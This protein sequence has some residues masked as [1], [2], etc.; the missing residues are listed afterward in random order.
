MS[1]TY[2]SL[3]QQMLL[4]FNNQH[5]EIAEK[6]AQSILKIN[7]EDVIALQILGLSTAMQN[8]ADEAIPPLARAAS[9]EP[10][11]PE[12]LINLVKAQQ[13]TRQFSEAIKTYE[14]LNSLMPNNFQI[15]TDM[16]TAYGKMNEYKKAYI[17]YTKAIELEPEYFL[18]WSNLGNLQLEQSLAKES[19][20]SYEVAL[21]KNSSYPETWTNYGNALYALAR[22]EEALLA[23][24]RALFLD[25]DYG[26]AWRNHGNTLMEL[27]RNE[28]A[29]VSYQKAYEIMPNQPFLIGH[30]LHGYASNCDWEGWRRLAPIA[31]NQVANNKCAVYPFIMLHSTDSHELQNIATNT[32]NKENFSSNIAH[33]FKLSADKNQ[34]IRI[35]YFSS[36]FREHPVGIL[37]E[38]ILANHDRSKFE[39]IGFFLTKPTADN[40][41]KRLVNLFDEAHDLSSMTDSMSY[42]HTRAQHLDIAIDLNGHTAG[43]K[44]ELFVKKV[45]PIQVN[46][47][48][49]AGSMN[50]S[51]YQYIIADRV[52]IPEEH[53]ALYTEK[54]AYLPHSFFPADTLIIHADLADQPS[55][56]SQ[57]L[58]E[59]GFIFACFNNS[60][61]ITQSIYEL[62]MELL[63]KTPNS[64]LWLTKP[65][66][67]A[68][69]NLQL[70]A[71]KYGVD[72]DRIIFAKRIASRKD[73]LS[74]LRLADLFL[75][76]P[77]FN[78]HTTAADA[79]W[80]AV[81][82]LTIQ[83][84]TFASRV[85]A[86]QLTA[87][88]MTELICYSEDE[89]FKKALELA[90]NQHL[91]DETKAS[92]V[93]NIK[94]S[95]L[96]NT[97]QYVKDLENL[98]YEMLLK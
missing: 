81:P 52:V 20:K 93:K 8:R 82:V 89:Y 63:K 76:T 15:L 72:P 70:S 26:E 45:A 91:H 21:S 94:S 75:D 7:S 84:Q 74:R 60:Y 96:F 95:A 62:W 24:S 79:L 86:S 27:R 57:G 17:C 71:E 59:T 25:P 14:S 73:H 92:L 98:Y 29:L 3:F 13:S 23:H 10:H 87:L 33:T 5:L 37:M 56:I 41:E 65:N 55:R 22:Y 90:T 42:E 58:P 85:A 49:Y 61:K 2:E 12:I 66:E 35:G 28:E 46:Y 80:G 31:M 39:L 4:E 18:A 32:F 50:L 53:H 69:K 19:I 67:S 6:L 40:L 11:N 38:N 77:L 68:I 16:G 51:S 34:K 44:T 30:L 48:G 97:G 47:L 9:L 64:V 36:D 54:I 1:Q 78:A 83:G 88:N 43:A